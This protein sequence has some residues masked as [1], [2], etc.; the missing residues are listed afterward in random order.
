MEKHLLCPLNPLINR[1]YAAVMRTGISHI[2]GEVDA[3][4]AARSSCPEEEIDRIDRRLVAMTWWYA[5]RPEEIAKETLAV[6]GW[7]AP[8]L[9]V[10]QATLVLAAIGEAGYPITGNGAPDYAVPGDQD[11]PPVRG[12]ERDRVIWDAA[13]Y[14]AEMAAKPLSYVSLGDCRGYTPRTVQ[15]DSP[16]G[17][18]PA[19]QA[20]LT[21]GSVDGDTS[22]HSYVRRH[23]RRLLLVR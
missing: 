3:L 19:Q 9:T 21:L 1:H 13:R 7:R 15:Y 10:D 17:L 20:A 4:V 14:W 2:R 12:A 5:V 18:H 11:L 16:G 23:T 8:R 22:S 6:H